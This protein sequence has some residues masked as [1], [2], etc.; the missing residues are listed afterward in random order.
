M[1]TRQERDPQQEA[2][3]VYSIL[4]E[5]GRS[6]IGVTGRPLLWQGPEAIYIKLQTRPLVREVATK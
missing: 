1:K 6:Y 2:Q 4:C 5:C 3:Y